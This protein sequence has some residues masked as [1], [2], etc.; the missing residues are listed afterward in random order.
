MKKLIATLIL[1]IS[2]VGIVNAQTTGKL[3]SNGTVWTDSLYYGTPGDSVIVLDMNF[4]YESYRIFLEGDANSPV[5]SVAVQ[6]GS[7][8]YNESKVAVDTV[9]SAYTALRIP[10]GTY[11]VRIVNTATGADVVLYSQPIQMIKISLMNYRGVLADRNVTVVIN[12]LRK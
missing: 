2:L 9:F 6:V 12:G 1:L 10:A 11:D 7:V 8:I 5:D 4:S 3:V